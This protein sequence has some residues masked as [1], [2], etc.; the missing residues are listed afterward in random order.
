MSGNPAITWSEA[1]RLVRG[2]DRSTFRTRAES[3]RYHHTKHGGDLRLWRYLV[4]ASEFDRSR[5]AA[6]LQQ[7]GTIIYRRR[8]GAFLIESSGG[9]VSYGRD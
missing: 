9:T 6:R 7:D 4:E 5:A 3:I 8:T 2:W 1:R